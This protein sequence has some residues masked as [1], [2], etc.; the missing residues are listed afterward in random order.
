MSVGGKPEVEREEGKAARRYEA[1]LAEVA[2]GVPPPDPDPISEMLL[3]LLHQQMQHQ[4]RHLQRLA[5]LDNYGHTH[6]LPTQSPPADDTVKPFNANVDTPILTPEQVMQVSLEEGLATEMDMKDEPQDT[7]VTASPEEHLQKRDEEEE[8]EGK[9]REEHKSSSNIFPESVFT[10]LR[11]G[12][13]S[14]SPLQQGVAVTGTVGAAF[15]EQQQEEQQQQQQ[16]TIQRTPFSCFTS[17]SLRLNNTTIPCSTNLQSPSKTP[18][19]LHFP[20]SYLS[21]TSAHTLSY[22][23]S[24]LGTNSTA[25]HLSQT[26]KRQKLDTLGDAGRLRGCGGGLS[27]RI[28][29][30]HC[31]CPDLHAIL[32][33]QAE[34]EHQ[35]RMKVLMEESEAGTK[36]H[37][38]RMR[39][40]SLEE[41]VLRARL[42]AGRERESEKGTD[43]SEREADGVDDG[44]DE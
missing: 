25:D 11:T 30:S 14:I 40:L 35:L 39:I 41:E 44:G 42:G 28:S 13:S 15:Q 34:Q 37:A 38:V 10:P 20:T 6:T 29:N 5:V 33:A 3:G 22:S 27:T 12:I 16:G 43:V 21:H 18:L 19:S 23:K 32:A 2:S 26:A 1:R 36:E 24:P 9:E 31:C 4:R 17:S 7:T 8:G